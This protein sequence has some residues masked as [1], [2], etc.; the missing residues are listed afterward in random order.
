MIQRSERNTRRE[1]FNPPQT[2]IDDLIARAGQHPL[3]TE[4]LADGALDAVS[5]VFRVHAFTVERARERLENG[6]G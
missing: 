2:A 4:F 1:T 6:R 3:G 5:A